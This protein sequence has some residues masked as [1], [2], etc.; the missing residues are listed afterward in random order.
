MTYRLLLASASPRRRE[1]IKY[2]GL[3]FECI[4]V[5][6]D[7]THEEATPSEAAME[8]ASKKARA[9]AGLREISENEIIIGADTTVVLG[10]KILGKPKNRADAFITLKELSGRTHQVY[11]GVCLIHKKA[12]ILREKCFF[13]VTDVTFAE[14]SDDETDAYLDINEY[15]DKAGSYAIQ[16]VFSRHISGIRGDYNNVVGLP[17]ARLYKEL[18]E[19]TG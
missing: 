15:A 1:L 19:L 10:D 5:D 3:D 13:E 4:S 18:H 9:C 7:E 16:G 17:V 14:L 12:G 8:I 2:L 6:A 11:T